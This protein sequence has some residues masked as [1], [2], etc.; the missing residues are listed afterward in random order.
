M[1]RIFVSVLVAVV[2]IA[3]GVMVTQ[4]ERVGTAYALGGDGGNADDSGSDNGG[5]G[6]DD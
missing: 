2:L 6:G 5:G 4:N 3:F 1:K